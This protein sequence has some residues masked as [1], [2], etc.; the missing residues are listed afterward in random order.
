MQTLPTPEKMAALVSGVTRTMCGLT[1][2]P[3]QKSD[4]VGLRWRTALLPI[5]G[6]RPLTVGISSDERGCSELGAAM[7]AIPRDQVDSSM[8][9]DSL[10]ELLNMTAG[11]LKS[12]M[13]LN[14][15]LGLPG[16]SPARRRRRRRRRARR[17]WS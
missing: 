5:P 4:G 12:V 8:M 11:L 9:N 15:A 1:F 14:Q 17:W 7:F 16:S 10:C 13:S 6:D 3:D 2:E